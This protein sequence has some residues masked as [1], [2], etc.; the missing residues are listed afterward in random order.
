MGA[1]VVVVVAD[2][3]PPAPG[4]RLLNCPVSELGLLLLIGPGVM[5]DVAPIED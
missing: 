3:E 2:A 1:V 4:F 5:G